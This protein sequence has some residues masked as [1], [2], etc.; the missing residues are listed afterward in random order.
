MLAFVIT[1]MLAEDAM[2]F[3]TMAV[4][5]RWKKPVSLQEGFYRSGEAHNKNEGNL[6]PF[7]TRCALGHTSEPMVVMTVVMI[8]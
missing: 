1:A 2:Q 4:I 6:T 3:F 5:E 8:R 7:C